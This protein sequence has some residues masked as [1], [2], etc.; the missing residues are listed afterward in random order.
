MRRMKNRLYDEIVSNTFRPFHP[1][2]TPIKDW[3][4]DSLESTNNEQSS[5]ENATT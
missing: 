4:K 3:M 1:N 2:L 5:D